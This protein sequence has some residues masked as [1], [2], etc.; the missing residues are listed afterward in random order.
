MTETV[1]IVGLGRIARYHVQALEEMEGVELIGGAD[2]SPSK[3]IEYNGRMLPVYDSIERL[4]DDQPA[5]VIVATPTRNHYETCRRIISSVWRPRRLVIEKPLATTLSEVVEVLTATGHEM[6]IAVVYH[7]AHAP[8]VLWAS[9]QAEQWSSAFGAV[10]SYEASFADPY[11]DMDRE[12]RDS[13]YGNSWLDSGINALSVALRFLRLESIRSV[14][15]IVNMVSTYEADVIFQSG[16]Q[17]GR[18]IIHTTWDVDEAAK[19]SEFSFKSGAKLTLDHQGVRGMLLQGDEVLDSFAYKGDQP[20]LALHYLN[21]FKSIFV[22]RTG[23]YNT[24]DD[25]LLHRLLLDT[26]IT[27]K[28]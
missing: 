16:N 26:A 5:T 8:E 28:K 2:V 13:V 3:R 21:A 20:R 24:E 1:A 4:L 23:Y 12:Q 17:E 11:S 18:G 6:D 15:S 14:S 25:L 9:V 19:R 22:D 27:E 10:V 7:A